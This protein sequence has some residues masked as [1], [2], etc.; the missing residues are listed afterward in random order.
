MLISGVFLTIVFFV[1]HTFW[2]IE[3]FRPAEASNLQDKTM[4][5]FTERCLRF[6]ASLPVITLYYLYG[7]K[8]SDLASSK[9]WSNTVVSIAQCSFGIYLLQEIVI[10]LFYY[11]S[12]LPSIILGS[13]LP[14]VT[15]VLAFVISYAISY[16]MS[17]S[18]TTKW[19]LGT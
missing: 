2:E 16:T 13:N 10:K 12:P 3:Y 15:F 17:Q 19:L 11:F 6:V 9:I 14:L 4:M 7:I 18:K 8:M 5:I 1:V